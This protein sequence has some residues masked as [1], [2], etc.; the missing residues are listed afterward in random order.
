MAAY[1][2]R[3][4]SDPIRSSY[5]CFTHL[6]S[7]ILNLPE[8][9]LVSCIWGLTSPISLGKYEKFGDPNLHPCQTGASTLTQLQLITVDPDNIEEYFTA[10]KQFRLNSVS[11]YN[12]PL[13]FSFRTYLSFSHNYSSFPCHRPADHTCLRNRF[14]PSASLDFYDSSLLTHRTSLQFH[15]IPPCSNCFVIVLDFPKSQVYKPS[16]RYVFP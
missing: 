14:L 6:A 11:C 8:T 7:F 1:A 13:F 12:S 9:G 10:C 5:Y 3:M 16:T 15:H 2:G 4:M